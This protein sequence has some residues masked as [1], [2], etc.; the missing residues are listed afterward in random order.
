MFFRF[1]TYY[2]PFA[3][4]KKVYCAVIECS[5]LYILIRTSWLI[6]VHK[7]LTSFLICCPL[8][9]SVTERGMLTSVPVKVDVSLSLLSSINFYFIYSEAMLLSLYKSSYCSFLLNWSFYYKISSYHSSNT[10][11]LILFFYLLW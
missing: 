10:S 5:I 1:V 2:V 9:L 11:A 4:G 8:L 3:L 7:S 6:K